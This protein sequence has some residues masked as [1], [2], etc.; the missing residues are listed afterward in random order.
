MIDTKNS[1]IAE[2]ILV[3]Y[4][5]IKN[6]FSNDNLKIVVSHF[7]IFTQD[8]VNSLVEG[9]EILMTSI[10]DNKMIRKRV[11][12]I[13]IEGLQNIRKHGEQDDLQRQLGFLI[14]GKNEKIYKINFGNIISSEES[15]HISKQIEFINE[16]T[17]EEI[18]KFYIKEL[19]ENVF[20]K[21]G[22]AG[23]GFIIMKMKSNNKLISNI[24]KINDQFSFLSL[25]TTLDRI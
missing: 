3:N 9:N 7:G 16:Q 24:K 19:S 5:E 15:S 11:F 14:I 20:S 10:G 12:S 22:G 2:D 1:L 6:N 8:L 25:E 18:K 21:K 23:L 17:S 13:L 4:Q